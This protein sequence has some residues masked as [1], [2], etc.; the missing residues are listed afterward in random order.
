MVVLYLDER[1]LVALV[2]LDADIEVRHAL[3]EL[4]VAAVI[5]DHLVHERDV[6]VAYGVEHIQ[7][8]GCV[9]PDDAEQSGSVNAARAA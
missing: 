3:D 5:C 8:S 6:L 9:A 7:N 2:R 4:A 1:G